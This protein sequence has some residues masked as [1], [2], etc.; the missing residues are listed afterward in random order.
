MKPDGTDSADT[1]QDELI[2]RVIPLRRRAETSRGSQPTDEYHPPR[3]P[4][5]R[6]ARS[7]W[8]PPLGEPQ[9]RRRQTPAAAAPGTPSASALRARAYVSRV[10]ARAITTA[11]VGAVAA[12]AVAFVLAGAVFRH[13]PSGSGSLSA[14][15]HSLI[16]TPIAAPPSALRSAPSHPTS[17]QGSSNGN[18]RRA[19]GTTNAA[20]R[21]RQ[22]TPAARTI[23]TA[24]LTSPASEGAPPVRASIPAR[25]QRA[26]AS[27]EA[28]GTCASREF[29]IEH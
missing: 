17:P 11:A 20:H 29:G 7:V 22:S 26:S 3:D 2:A 4:P 1:D 25:Q 12:A 15:A 27:C 19:L 10:P 28:Q 14:G 8:D 5:S 24:L 13:D 21:F 9:L 23:E 6:Q 16:G 18:T